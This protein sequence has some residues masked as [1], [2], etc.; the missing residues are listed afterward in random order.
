M[1][2]APHEGKLLARPIGWETSNIA[3][4]IGWERPLED[5]VEIHRAA[6][7]ESQRR[8]RLRRE[9]EEAERRLAVMRRNQA[10]LQIERQVRRL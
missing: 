4:P 5:L 6:A 7:E 10:I 1:G 8:E 3:R 2:K 9:R